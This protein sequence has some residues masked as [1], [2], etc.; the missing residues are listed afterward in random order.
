MFILSFLIASLIVYIAL[1]LVLR[2]VW[3][4]L[5]HRK[6]FNIVI[7]WVDTKIE[8]YKKKLKAASIL[9]IIVF[10]WVPL[11]TTGLWN[12]DALEYII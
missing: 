6:Y 1:I 4:Y 7:G 11:L 2:Q 12:G 5:R 9:C 10:L 3:D 8:N